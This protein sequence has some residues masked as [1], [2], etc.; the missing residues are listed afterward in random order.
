MLNDDETKAL[1]AL[2][3]VPLTTERPLI[4]VML[5]RAVRTADGTEFQPGY[6]TGISPE[7]ACALVAM[8]HA[9]H[10]PNPTP[11]QVELRKA[12]EAALEKRLKAAKSQSTLESQVTEGAPTAW[13][14]DGEKRR[15]T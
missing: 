13:K 4:P 5:N 1:Q 10:L 6:Y 9:S 8:G 15:K 7:G 11:E 12:G 3:A 14:G 2:R